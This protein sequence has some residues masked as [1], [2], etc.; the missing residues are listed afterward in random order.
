MAA[1]LG[2]EP[3]PEGGYFLETYR[4]A[5]TVRTPRGERPASTAILFLITEESASR[6]HRLASD[7]LWVY[8]GGLPLE[9]VTIAPEGELRRRVL[10]DLEEIVR[11]RSPQREPAEEVPVGLPEGERDWL[12]QALVPAGS[13][14]GARLAGGPHLPAQYA[15]A[16]VSCVVTPGFDF[17]DF[18]LADRAALLG[19][20]PQHAEVIGELT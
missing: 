17:A 5:Q 7:E 6:L 19:E 4:A 14:Q 9:L 2:L 11:S 15:W 16:L 12:T 10:G 3:H 13:W 1:S 18:E 20:F 8:Q